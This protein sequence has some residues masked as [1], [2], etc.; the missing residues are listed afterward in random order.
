[1][2]ATQCKSSAQRDFLVG[3]TESACVPAADEASNA[4]DDIHGDDEDGE[5][6]RDWDIYG[7]YMT[8]MGGVYRS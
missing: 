1:M 5:E 6:G 3:A 7:P 4:P 8:Q 2:V